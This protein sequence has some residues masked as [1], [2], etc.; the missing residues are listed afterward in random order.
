MLYS[1]PTARELLVYVP[2]FGLHVNWVC[3]TRKL[4][5]ITR[6]PICGLNQTARLINLSDKSTLGFHAWSATKH[7]GVYSDVTPAIFI[8]LFFGEKEK[9]RN[10]RNKMPFYLSWRKTQTKGLEGKPSHLYQ[11]EQDSYNLRIIAEYLLHNKIREKIPLNKQKLQCIGRTSHSFS[12][13]FQCNP[14]AVPFAGYPSGSAILTVQSDELVHRLTG[15]RFHA[16]ASNLW[17]APNP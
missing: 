17:A 11:S 16:S 9:E 7:D 4:L 6:M 1:I 3:C 8:Y 2:E 14:H 12:F 5:L 15:T 10:K 13:S